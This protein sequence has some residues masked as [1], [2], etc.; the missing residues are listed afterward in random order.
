[1]CPT[2]LGRLETRVAT[3]IGP[4]LLGALLSLVTANP[5]YV[6]LIGVLLLMGTVIDTAFY[7][8]MIKWQP[9]G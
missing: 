4:A 9:P 6:V 7:P 3:L 8:L 1:V 5:G 2:V